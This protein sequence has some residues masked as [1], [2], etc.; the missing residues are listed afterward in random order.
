MTVPFKEFALYIAGAKDKELMERYTDEFKQMNDHCTKNWAVVEM[1]ESRG[2]VIDTNVD[3]FF[4]GP[5]NNGDPLDVQVRFSTRYVLIILTSAGQNCDG[6]C[7]LYSP[8]QVILY[9]L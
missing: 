9:R 6:S 8:V 5:S 4:D 7:H 3:I 1:C 2:I